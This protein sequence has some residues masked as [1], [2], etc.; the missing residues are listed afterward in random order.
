HGHL[1]PRAHA[2][3]GTSPS[4]VR[5]MRAKHPEMASNRLPLDFKSSNWAP[6]LARC[7]RTSGA[8]TQEAEMRAVGISAAC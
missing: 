1:Q 2:H 8:F 5:T 7:C 6:K 3:L 4:A